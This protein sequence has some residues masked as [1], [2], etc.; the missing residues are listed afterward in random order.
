MPVF[1]L[2]VT[3]VDGVE[4]LRYVNDIRYYRQSLGYRMTK[5]M[6]PRA[7][8]I[9]WRIVG[10]LFVV[11]MAV[12]C[13]KN[14]SQT[15]DEPIHAQLGYGGGTTFETITGGTAHASATG[16]ITF[17]VQLTRVTP[18]LQWLI[19]LS[20]V[21]SSILTTAVVLV[22]GVLWIRTS[23]GRPFAQSV[24]RSL[25]ALSIIV[26]VLGT[27]QE[28]LDS[29]VRMRAA[30][31]AIGDNLQSTSPYYN[32]EGFAISGIAIFIALGIG[33]LASAFAI[34]ARLTRDTEGLV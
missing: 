30:Y 15:L 9:A 20:N 7:E 14:I 13:W 22:F 27:L 34:G 29:W 16:V 24:T 5:R 21:N 10:A 31:E 11:A 28:A 8:A 3:R 33:V 32:A 1:A 18:H 2:G 6:S 12:I 19:A 23:A 25:G 17:G 26:A 4:R